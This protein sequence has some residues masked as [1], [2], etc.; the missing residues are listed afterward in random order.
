[1]EKVN[2]ILEQ[3]GYCKERNVDISAILHMYGEC[4][5]HYNSKRLYAKK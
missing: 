4:G 3:A 2:I 1:M 5:Y